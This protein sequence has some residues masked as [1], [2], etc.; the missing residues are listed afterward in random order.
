MSD[1]DAKRLT[2]VCVSNRIY[3]ST[4]NAISGHIRHAY[5]TPCKKDRMTILDKLT[6][7]SRDWLSKLN[8]EIRDF[9][10]FSSS[11]LFQWNSENS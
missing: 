7:R 5:N 8:L 6:Y 11:V 3:V 9:V 10:R 2:C 4:C 1:Y